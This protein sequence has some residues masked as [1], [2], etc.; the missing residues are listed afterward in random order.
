MVSRL[1][2]CLILEDLQLVPAGYDFYHFLSMFSYC[3]HFISIGWI[4]V[5]VNITTTRLS[6]GRPGGGSTFAGVPKGIYGRVSHFG[7]LS[8]FLASGTKK[9]QHREKRTWN[10]G[11]KLKKSFDLHLDAQHWASKW[12]LGRLKLLFTNLSLQ[13]KN[14]VGVL[15]DGFEFWDSASPPNGQR[16]KV[17]K[18][19]WP[20]GRKKTEVINAPQNR[21]DRRDHYTPKRRFFSTLKTDHFF[22][23]VGWNMIFQTLGLCL[24]DLLCLVG[25]FGSMFPGS[26][27]ARWNGA[28]WE[29]WLAWMMGS[30]NGRKWVLQVG[31]YK[32]NHIYIILIHPCLHMI[33]LFLY[34]RVYIYRLL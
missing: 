8:R 13:L 2:N 3:K 15:C 23:R 20:N 10:V 6:R 9:G 18:E 22:Q 29:G 28:K 14:F 32:S 16:P 7:G 33:C 11:L 27:M 25:G 19:I 1:K 34:T 12:M 24:R 4:I 30:W 21:R 26:E 31:I 17:I 5:P